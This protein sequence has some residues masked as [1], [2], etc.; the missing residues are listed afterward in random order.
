MTTETYT[1]TDS[2]QAARL[3]LRA[4][5]PTGTARVDFGTGTDYLPAKHGPLIVIG[6]VGGGPDPH[7]SVDLPVLSF[8]VWGATKKQA[9]D[10][11]TLLL[12]LL[13]TVHGADTPAG[14][15]ED[16][17]VLTVLWTPDT[18]GTARYVIDAQLA[19]KPTVGST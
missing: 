11:K 3:W 2:E 17:R 15:L 10:V 5:L 13:H 1:Y 19:V 14:V 12:G 18:D 16:V 9:S 4:A 8:T 7:T 6:Q